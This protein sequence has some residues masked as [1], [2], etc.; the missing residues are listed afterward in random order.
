MKN[1][2]KAT[3]NSLQTSLYK[4]QYFHT[5]K[6]KWLMSKIINTKLFS[7]LAN[8]SPVTNQEIE[9]AYGHF[10]EHMRTASQSEGNYSEVFRMLN[11]TRVELAFLQSSYRHEEGEKMP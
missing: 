5:I 11:I 6:T 8:A 4:S 2:Q 7:L 1:R 9:N 3:K 10:T